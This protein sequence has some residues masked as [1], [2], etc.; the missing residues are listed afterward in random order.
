MQTLQKLGTFPSA[1]ALL[2]D[3]VAV[4]KM[5]HMAASVGQC[6]YFGIGKF[7]IVFKYFKLVDF[8]P[9]LQWETT[10]VASACFL[11]GKPL[12]KRVS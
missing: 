7:L 5:N 1:L 6:C 4:T 9:F 11:V 12:W 2:T 3:L 8:L 10:F